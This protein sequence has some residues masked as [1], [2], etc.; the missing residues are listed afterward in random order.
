MYK[1]VYIILIPFVLAIV[2]A[3]CTGQEQQ[4]ASAAGEIKT[5]GTIEENEYRYTITDSTTGLT[6]Y[7]YNDSDNLYMGIETETEGWLSVGFDPEFAMKGANIIFLAIEDGQAKARDDYGTANFAHQPDTE[8]GGTDDMIEYAASGTSFEFA[9]PLDSGDE[10]DKKLEPG[11]QYAIIM[12]VNDRSTDFD[13]K[14]TARSKAT[15]Q[16]D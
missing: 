13:A 10:Y 7:W 2:L 9:I 11:S 12:A 16:L 4:P 8:L 15:I 3:G 1:Y 6:L 14:H 5:D